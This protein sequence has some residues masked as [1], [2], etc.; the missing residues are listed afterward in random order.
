[1]I[2]NY[3]PL[4]WGKIIILELLYG[5]GLRKKELTN[6][7]LDDIDCQ[8]RTVRVISGK[9]QKDRVV[10]I[11]KVAVVWL[12]KYVEEV[13]TVL[14]PKSDYLFI[15]KSGYQATG[16]IIY[17]AV[18]SYSQYSCH[19][20]RHAYATHLLQNGMKETSLQR[21]LGHSCITT[22]QIYTKVTIKDLK[23]S[24]AK[25]HQRDRWN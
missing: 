13:R 24:Y 23:T 11:S 8:K 18:K 22:T 3:C 2:E 4:F 10:P 20:Y 25:Y 12:K 6:L 1:M 16:A 14:K 5:A 9:N 21:L 19:K 15:A 7:K 17:N